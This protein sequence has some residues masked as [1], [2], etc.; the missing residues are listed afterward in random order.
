MIPKVSAQAKNHKLIPES[1][2]PKSRGVTGACR[3][4]NQR[5]SDMTHNNLTYTIASDPTS[6]VG[7]TEQLLH[8]VEAIN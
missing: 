8:F 2:I 5:A 4:M 7:S 1:G 3:F 6:E